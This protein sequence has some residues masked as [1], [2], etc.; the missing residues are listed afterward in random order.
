MGPSREVK[1]RRAQ[2]A[3]IEAMSAD[4]VI[5]DS[6][7]DAFLYTIPFVLSLVLALATAW[8][9]WSWL[10]LPQDEPG[11]PTGKTPPRRR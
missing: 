10:I 1:I 6:S 9:Y 8:R 4:G 11:G 5:L 7:T 2:Y 3:D